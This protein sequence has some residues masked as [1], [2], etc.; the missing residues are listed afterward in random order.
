MKKASLIAAVFLLNGCHLEKPYLHSLNVTIKDNSPCFKVPS[1]IENSYQIIKN[2]GVQIY[3]KSEQDWELFWHSPPQPTFPE[4]FS[5]ECL[6][7]QPIKWGEGTYSVLMGISADNDKKR[8][9]LENTF[10]LHRD[11][12]GNFTIWDTQ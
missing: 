12:A 2:R 3:K 4:I 5:G 9:R 7:Y 11:K 8:Y 6:L 10:T 1:D